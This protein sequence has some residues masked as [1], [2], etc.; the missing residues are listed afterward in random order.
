MKRPF[1][2][3]NNLKKNDE[4]EEI[5]FDKED[6][7]FP[8]DNGFRSRHEPTR[9]LKKLVVR[10]LRSFIT[11]TN[12]EGIRELVK[13]KFDINKPRKKL[14]LKAPDA[15]RYDYPFTHSP[16]YHNDKLVLNEEEHNAIDYGGKI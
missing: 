13:K 14:G 9:I 7:S 10:K 4:K 1:E 2:M 3:F 5:D 11:D 8:K 12:I 16:L 15:I 6:Y